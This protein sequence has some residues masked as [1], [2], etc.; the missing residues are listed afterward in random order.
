MLTNIVFT[1]FFAVAAVLLTV[2]LI[3]EKGGG[4]ELH[5]KP[6]PGIEP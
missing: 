6:E 1:P 4:V 5:S 3:R 2:D